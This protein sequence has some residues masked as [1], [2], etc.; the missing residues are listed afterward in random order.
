MRR[1]IQLSEM[2]FDLLKRLDIFVGR[3]TIYVLNSY[4]NFANPKA[5]N[6]G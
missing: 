1:S 5:A 2:L 3:S 6:A 4:F